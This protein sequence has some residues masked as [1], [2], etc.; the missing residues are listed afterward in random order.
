MDRETTL[1]AL[2][3]ALAL[4]ISGRVIGVDAQPRDDAGTGPR[5]MSS[6]AMGQGMM[7]QGTSGP[8]MMHSP[9]PPALGASGK[10]I[11]QSQCSQCHALQ[12]GSSD[13]VGPNL[14]DL[15]GR[16]AGTTLGYSY[17]AAMRDSGVVWTDGTLDQFI[18][19]PQ[20]YIHGDNMAFPGITDKTARQRLV[21]YL[22]AATK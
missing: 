2:L 7:G 21:A 8:G 20:R 1:S 19:A 15:F 3:V 14:H 12:P 16:K 4:T 10:A 13:L 18:E 9:T 22:K 5:S 11:F 17:S 6:G